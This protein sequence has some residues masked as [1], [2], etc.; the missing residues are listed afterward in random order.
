VARE[1][2]RGGRH[3]NGIRRRIPRISRTALSE[4]LHA[5]T[6]VGFVSRVLPCSW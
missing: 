4:R 1:L 6:D 3:F 2:L 5:L